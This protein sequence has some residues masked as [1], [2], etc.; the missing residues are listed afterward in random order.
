MRAKT[1][2]FAVA[3]GVNGIAGHFV[4]LFFSCGLY[5][6]FQRQHDFER[7]KQW[8]EFILNL[9]VKNLNGENETERLRLSFILQIIRHF[10]V[11]VCG[12]CIEKI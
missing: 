2:V 12:V 6:S 4:L 9:N 8:R 5:F 7:L 3:I 10:C 1:F 11:S